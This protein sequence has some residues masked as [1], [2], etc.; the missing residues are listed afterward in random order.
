MRYYEE[1]GPTTPRARR[2]EYLLVKDN[3]DIY[4]ETRPFFKFDVGGNVAHLSLKETLRLVSSLDERLKGLV[5]P[6]KPVYLQSGN[7]IYL[8]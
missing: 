7:V 1:F 3:V 6:D 5:K 4:E 2:L 8:S